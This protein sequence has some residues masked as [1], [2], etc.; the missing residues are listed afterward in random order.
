MLIFMDEFARSGCGGLNASIFSFNIALPCIIHS[1]S[2]EMK[3]RIARDVIEGRKNMSLCVTEPNGGSDVANLAC[4]AIEDGKG[5][6]IVNG[7]KYFITSGM[8]SEYFVVAVRTGKP[9]FMGVSLLL[10]E[11]DSP[12]IIKQRMKTMG[13]WSSNTAYLI[14]KNVVVP[15]KNLIGPKN[16]GFVPIMLNFN[17]E[18]MGMIVQTNRYARVCLEDAI[19][20]AKERKTFGKRLIDHQV[21]R[22]KIVEMS[23]RIESVHAWIEQIAYRYESGENPLNLAR[24][25]AL[26]K[27]QSTTTFEFCAKEALQIFGG[28]GYI[29]G[30]RAGRVE[31]LYREVRVMAIAGGSE[32]IMLDLAARQSK[33]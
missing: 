29:R 5:N 26:L 17:Q 22:H 3:D 13:W 11:S 31:R 2:K 14:F 1:G 28:R 16:F 23:S 10:I 30:G 8:K 27:V 20:Y 12:G 4:T 33:L 32:E 21:I 24:D 15:K 18:R 6:Y 25:I 7:E 9:G 19:K